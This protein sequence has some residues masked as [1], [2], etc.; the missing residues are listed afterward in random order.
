MKIF[1]T[2]ALRASAAAL[3]LLAANCLTA[4]SASAPLVDKI[5]FRMEGPQQVSRDAV[6]AHM[7]LRSGMPFDQGA[8]DVSI[9]S[10]YDTDLYETIEATRT[11]T[12]AGRLNIDIL[13]RPKYRIAQV[14]FRGNKVY[15]TSRLQEEITSRAGGILDER[16]VKRDADKLDEFY[17]K[18]GYSLARAKSSIE[19]DNETGLGVVI[20]D[21]D[22]GEDIKIQNIF[23]TGN[24]HIGA[25]DLR[26][27]MKTDT[28]VWLISYLMEYGRFK[29]D[30]FQKDIAAL[31]QYYRN[32]GYLDVKIDESKVRFD[33]P[34]PDNPGYMDLTI[35]VEE[36]RQYKTG[37]IEF[38]IDGTKLE[39][40]IKA[41]GRA[42]GEERDLYR[43]LPMGMDLWEGDIFS[44]ARLDSSLAWIKSFYGE[45][46]YLDAEAVAVRKPNLET[47]A[48]DLVINVYEREKYYLESI[49]IQGNTK[50]QSEV[51][52]RE[53]AL[54]PGEVFHRDRMKDSEMRLRNTR[55]FDEVSLDDEKTNIPGR[56]DLR[57]IV[58]EGRT[59]NMVFGAGFSTVESFVVTAEISQSNFDFLNWRNMF[60]G[61]GQKFR[62]RGTLGLESNQIL[63]SFSNPWIFNR[64]LEY[65]FELY[66]T[67]S[68]YYSD[69]Y[70]EVRT[71]MMHYIR[72]DLFELVEGRLG[73]TLEDVDLYDVNK[74][75]APEQVVEE[76]GH[77][78]VS[79]LSLSFLREARDNLMMPTDGTRFEILQ[80][81]AGGPLMGQ[82]NIY[83]V[84]ARGGWW[85]PVSRHFGTDLSMFKYGDQVF[86]IVGRTGSITGFGGKEV[87]YF[88]KYFLGGAYNL[89]GYKYRKA[90]PLDRNDEPLGGNT[91]GYISLEY[92]VR[93]IEQFRIAAF[94]DIGF[95]NESSWD[96]DPTDYSDDIG[97]G[98]RILLMGAPM[99]IDI[100]VPVTKGNAADN[101]VQFNF[102]FGTVF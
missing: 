82:T 36:G 55:F 29:D 47:G 53:L 20:F 65:G 32:H 24:E 17:R 49:N 83:K 23:F 4:Q 89:R 43:E 37:K 81:V 75:K 76:A 31:R 66:R 57:I 52:I 27:Q 28:W 39:E 48:I 87:P 45:F 86:S 51:I 5:S 91:F 62:I 102:S 92:S 1:N 98:F 41:V 12:P 77:R 44:P 74:D 54:Q 63:V 13:I 90:G 70:S 8:L 101:G 84:E 80:Q 15:R 3:A 61:G 21:V 85:F 30:D 26:A 11:L 64:R 25:G 14:V 19:R 9:K 99:R 50:T 96:W 100:G 35:D 60:T 38:K 40:E 59:G 69:Y 22:E 33:F 46:G 6:M 71:G 78:S 18:K 94:Y 73:Y 88:E 42:K 7:K 97:I 95:L 68:G 56:R 93:I 72:K 67:D 34:D 2:K 16:R 58:K 79:K 10:L